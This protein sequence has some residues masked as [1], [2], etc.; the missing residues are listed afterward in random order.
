MKMQEKIRSILVTILIL[1]CVYVWWVMSDGPGIMELEIV[2]KK[3][4]AS[5]YKAR[6]HIWPFIWKKDI[7]GN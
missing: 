4:H 1:L 6:A 5:V 7:Y 3:V 2:M